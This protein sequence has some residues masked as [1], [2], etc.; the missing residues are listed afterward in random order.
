MKKAFV[1]ILTTLLG[2][3]MLA[4]LVPSFLTQ[5]TA[6]PSAITTSPGTITNV[7]TTGTN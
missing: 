1:I 5:P 3:S 7:Q 2:L 6:A 4:F